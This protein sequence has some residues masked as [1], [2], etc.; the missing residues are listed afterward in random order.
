MLQEQSRLFQRSLFVADA[1]IVVVGW[2]A[3][4][5]I[6]FEL[7]RSLGIMSPPEWLPLSRYLEFLPWVLPISMSVFW[8][9]GLYVP[10]RAQRLPRLVFVVVRAVLL[11]VLLLMM[12]EGFTQSC[13]HSFQ[14]KKRKL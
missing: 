2:I 3:A 10:D 5:F 4:Y 6:R 12:P 7:L 8:L 13:Q 11:G 1:L 9:S 14:T